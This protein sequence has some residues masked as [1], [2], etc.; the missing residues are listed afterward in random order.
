MIPWYY[1]LVNNSQWVPLPCMVFHVH[2]K[3]YHHTADFSF[4]TDS[5]I[6]KAVILRIDSPGGDALASDL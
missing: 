6:Y 3:L 4:L 5:K 2:D 1:N